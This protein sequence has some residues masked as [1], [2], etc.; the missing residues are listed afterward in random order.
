ML[1]VMLTR[2]DG[3]YMSKFAKFEKAV[4]SSPMAGK[5]NNTSP[6]EDDYRREQ[7]KKENN[8]SAKRA[9]QK[10]KTEKKAQSPIQK[11]DKIAQFTDMLTDKWESA[12]GS[13]D[14][15]ASRAE[16]SR[17]YAQKAVEEMKRRGLYKLPDISDSVQRFGR[18]R[19]PS[20]G[21]DN[22][23]RPVQS[24]NAEG[25]GAWVRKN[26]W[27]GW[28]S[29]NKS[30]A[31]TADFLLPTEFLGKYDFISKANDYYTN[32]YN[33]AAEDAERLN[34][35][36][37][38]PWKTGGELVAGS[39]AALPNALI[40]LLTSGTSA[41][42]PASA[43][44]KSAAINSSS[45]ISTVSNAVKTMMKNPSYWT[46]V[47]QTMGND[48]EEAKQRG[49]GDFAAAASA[50]LTSAVNAGIEVG[51]GIETLPKK[52]KGSGKTALLEWVNSTLDE[53]KEEVL[54][55]IVSNA[56]AKLLYDRKAPL[57]SLNDD[58]AVLN[59]VKSAKEFT[60]GAAVGG[61]LGAGQT[62]L[63]RGIN[64][65]RIKSAGAE[66]RKSGQV[67]TVI[68]QGL[69][70]DESSEAYKNADKMARDIKS[71][72]APS[73]V[74]IGRLC[75]DVASAAQNDIRYKIQENEKGLYVQADRQ[76]INSDDDAVRPYEIMKHVKN[77]VMKGHD[78]DIVLDDGETIT[79]TGRTA[80]KLGDKGN[81]SNDLYLVKG[82][83]AGVIDEIVQTS[84]MKNHRASYKEHS[85]GFAQ[86]GF[87]YRN[88]Y[89]RDLDGKYYKLSLSVGVN[90]DGKEA[91]NIGAIKEIPFPGQ[92]VA[93]KDVTGYKADSGIQ[94]AVDSE[95]VTGSKTVSESKEN[96]LSPIRAL[97]NQFA[98][99]EKVSSDTNI[100]QNAADVNS[101]FI[102]NSGEVFGAAR[103]EAAQRFRG[104]RPR[105]FEVI[106]GIS[107]KLS[108]TSVIDENIEGKDGYWNPRTRE[109]HINAN[110]QN[111]VSVIL[112]HEI[113]HVLEGS[114]QYGEII[115]FMKSS[116]ADD[117][118]SRRQSIADT[119][120][121][122]NMRK[123][124]S[125]RLDITD[126]MLDSET[127]AEFAQEFNTDE[128]IERVATQKPGM[129]TK[130]R[131]FVRD[132][133]ERIKGVFSRKDLTPWEQA[134]KK[135]ENA[136]RAA[137]NEG[138]KS[139]AETAGANKLVTSPTV[140][141]SDTN[142][143]HEH[144]NV[145][146]IF[147]RSN[148]KQRFSVNSE[149]T[150][151]DV[152][153][154]Q[155][156]GRK[157]VNDFSSEDF[158]KTENFARKYFKE[159]GTKSPFF[160]SWFGDWR[161]NDTTPVE[162]TLLKNNVSLPGDN[163]R[164][165]DTGISAFLG[166]V[167]KQETLTHAKS[168]N[169]TRYGLREKLLNNAEELFKN[170][171]LLD[172]VTS[173]PTGHKSNN[174]TMMHSFYGICEY[175]NQK[176]VY[177]MFVEEFMNEGSIQ[178]RGY[179]IKDIKT[180]PT[181]S[182]EF[183][184]NNHSAQPVTI[185][186]DKTAPIASVRVQEQV[187][188]SV[189][190]TIGATDT[191]PQTGLDVNG[192]YIKNRQQRVR[193][194]EYIPSSITLTADNNTIPQAAD[195]VN[196]ADMKIPPESKRFSDNS[197]ASSDRRNIYTVSQLFDLVKAADKN[198]NPKMPSAVINEDGTPK[199]VY[200]GTDADFTVFEHV[201]TG[202]NFGDI[203]DGVFFFTSYKNAYPNSAEDYARNS[204][205]NNG[206]APKVKEVYLDIKNP[207]RLDSNGYYS[208][209]EYY[210][211]NSEEIYNKF[212]NGDYDGIIIENSD[213]SA[214]DA[215][216]YI[217]DNSTQIKSAT[218]NIG[219]FDKGN[220]DIRYKVADPGDTKDYLMN[221]PETWSDERRMQYYKARKA[222]E[223][224][225]GTY[226]ENR[227]KRRNLSPLE[228]SAK[229]EAALTQ[230][231]RNARE[232]A[233]SE[234]SLTDIFFEMSPEERKKHFGNL[235]EDYELDTDMPEK[236]AE[237][238]EDW[239]LEMKA[240]ALG[241]RKIR[242]RHKGKL[243][244]EEWQREVGQA[245]DFMHER[246]LE[247]ERYENTIDSLKKKIAGD[248]IDAA[249]EIE[250]LRSLQNKKDY[251]KA[252]AA[253]NALLKKLQSSGNAAATPDVIDYLDAQTQFEIFLNRAD[254]LVD[255][256]LDDLE[257]R[258][259]SLA[260]EIRA[261]AED[262]RKLVRRVWGDNAAAKSKGEEFEMIK[263]QMEGEDIPDGTPKR[264]LRKSP[265]KK[266]SA[267]DHVYDK[268]KIKHIDTVDMQRARETLDVIN[269]L[270]SK[271][272]LINLIIK[273]SK[274]RK[275][276]VH[277]IKKA[278]QGQEIVFLKDI[279]VQ[280]LFN[281]ITDAE[282]VSLGRKIST[283]QTM[284]HL[285]NGRTMTGNIT[286]NTAFSGTNTVA[287]WV[288]APVDKLMS[289]FTRKRTVGAE[290]VSLSN[291]KAG[292]QRAATQYIDIALAVD[293]SGKGKY[294]INSAVRTFQNKSL[295]TFE[296]TMGYG[297][298]VTDEWQKGI[299]EDRVRKSLEKLKNCGFTDKEI[300]EIA[301]YEAKYRTF[302]DT[303]APSQFM[304]KLKEAF[305][306]IGIKD[307]G[308]GDIIQKYTQ[309]P[310]AIIS[311][312]AEFTPLGYIK[313]L[314]GISKVALRKNE[315]T[316]AMQRNIAMSIGR[317]TT[318]TGLIML[319]S[320]LSKLGIFVGDDSDDDS[321][322][323]QKL[324]KA[325]GISGFQINL[326][327]LER[328]AKREDPKLKKGDLL[329]SI[330]FLEPL[331]V[332]MA[333]GYELSKGKD[334][335]I[336]NWANIC[337]AQVF[338]Q[339]AEIPAMQSLRNFQNTIDYGGNCV[340]IAIGILASGA[341]GFIP[342][343]VRQT[344][345]FL[346][347]IQRNPYKEGTPLN[348]GIEQI[349]ATIPFMRKSVP[350]SITPYGEE[351]QV[352]KGFFNN[353]VNRG[354][355]SV[356]Q[357]GDISEELYRMAEVSSDVLPHVPASKFTID[358]REFKLYGH[359]YEEY[360]KAVG[361]RT[362]VLLKGAIEHG[363]YANLS[364]EDKAAVLASLANTA[365]KEAQDAY[366][367]RNLKEVQNNADAAGAAIAVVGQKKFREM[368]DR[369]SSGE[370][371]SAVLDGTAKHDD[372]T[373]RSQEQRVH[374]YF[375]AKLSKG[376]ITKQ[377]A[378]RQFN[379]YL[380][381]NLEMPVF[382]AYTEEK[383]TYSQ[384]TSKQRRAKDEAMQKKEKSGEISAEE[385]AKW[386]DDFSHD[387]IEV[388]VRNYVFDNYSDCDDSM[389]KKLQKK[390]QKRAFE[391][392][393]REVGKQQ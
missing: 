318:G 233:D 168:K 248:D 265:P 263:H 336:K 135:W 250:N 105:Y 269:S 202:K 49:A 112:K 232:R 31:S 32:V 157:S 350:A 50:I 56:A 85:G 176:Y 29:F 220:P 323:L 229:A 256:Q 267:L 356:Y 392:A 54:Q 314:N 253:A 329:E 43:A 10:R 302:Q 117:W 149:I 281:T 296:R 161:A 373:S 163:I 368:S 72:K 68:E 95:A 21:A 375:V 251:K 319:F 347:P 298:Q 44:L 127:M 131:D 124:E 261:E 245:R 361:R 317:A 38:A 153:S 13:I 88:A 366:S 209:N 69:S 19:S 103:T 293:H 287:S 77:N 60:M 352:A 322:Q 164:N 52:L 334:F 320:V 363:D 339:I 288:A 246:A 136:A 386:W 174:T 241:W 316:A 249:G 292:A 224:E 159:V 342:S 160:R 326:S 73:D 109:L 344:G 297:L 121:R 126:S 57:M 306:V 182:K 140:I 175:E 89:F 243:S 196:S 142:I 276:Q 162:N 307:F 280:Q 143:S 308:L 286:S 84:K 123:S 279:A 272:D 8:E 154:V 360:S 179:E 201:Q 304:T 266:K 223:I 16:L 115:D 295:G 171:I 239:S 312:S 98:R 173:Q 80:W 335:S 217:V 214:D 206:G 236:M 389:K 282:G 139:N 340:D 146:G 191:I 284:S 187:P 275:T 186:I 82:N 12:R 291:Y 197:L 14:T 51:G 211:R 225:E 393:E 244:A 46:S 167:L 18:F 147:D 113:T 221:G 278:L 383:R 94:S 324:K 237:M 114:G 255:N 193:S 116:F 169:Q 37:G 204:A 17:R 380:D 185:G 183:D 145:N 346:D 172:S 47:L 150:A 102:R 170:A 310:G 259:P 378:R 228:A 87:D 100:P 325:E 384:L 106:D 369:F 212:F 71:G 333:I 382:E 25:L 231:S 345:N 309:V 2:K 81:Y 238:P 128:F 377:E 351:K 234:K 210:D 42:A 357:P 181:A 11:K 158:I 374:D 343:V 45:K 70:L 362:H 74:E 341:T 277:G 358:G 24:E 119:Y 391:E 1:P 299:A 26:A 129:I 151:D 207:L 99:E 27:K 91:Y 190:N 294:D 376:E 290:K 28:T 30:V 48:Y 205:N 313:A 227:E 200:H 78:L 7:R 39:V 348:K 242:E 195:N 180:I 23:R 22:E 64:S 226:E 184:L 15:P 122:I 75:A 258:K 252:A 120:E 133:I 107:K 66:I 93:P 55:G 198:F 53:G 370:N 92:T 283:Y 390:L 3:R 270:N 101:N 97:N 300:T 166:S 321:K 208:T 61:I 331:N 108:I 111:P 33:Q 76:V 65:A 365:E 110:A 83:A 41:A 156:I 311:R 59:L 257:K 353:F 240:A 268:Y 235:R 79:I 36:K 305:N 4:K 178:R 90:V 367:N 155:S 125:E 132:V 130:V 6:S 230:E 301:E 188:S 192:E 303:T 254:A 385:Y 222:R 219:T 189:T 138:Y 387:R 9:E 62:A 338:E 86:N 260:K 332:E 337:S 289:I 349:K 216:L 262:A 355:M 104:V 134:E 213:K 34:D 5:L 354:Y 264:L 35:K 148:E 137:V 58:T 388:E 328:L 273:Q 327:A 381:G 247:R 372:K 218:D 315:M 215:V 379:A 359:D 203:A 177:K 165:A 118:Q 141:A 364:D 20:Y 371:I 67:N 271:E 152:L 63:Y 144:S 285:L 40:A 96:P 199:V 274:E 194:S 330:G